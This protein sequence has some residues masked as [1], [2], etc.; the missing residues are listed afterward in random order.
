MHIAKVY[1]IMIGAPSDINEEI[2]IAKN[3]IHRWNVINSEY[4]R[5][6]LLPLHW[7]DN[8]YPLSGEHPQKTIDKTVV[9]KSDLLICIFCSRLGSP[10]DT[11]QSGSLE[12]ID[13][14]IKAGKDV[15]LF[16][17]K[18]VPTPQNA[19]DIEQLQKLISYKNS[20]QSSNLWWEYNDV[21]DFGNLL[22]EK[23]EL[24]VNDKWLSSEN[25]KNAV[26]EEGVVL[27]LSKTEVSIPCGSS[28]YLDIDGVEIDKCSLKLLDRTIG[29]A[30]ER[31]ARIKIEGYK[32]GTTKLIVSYRNLHAECLVTMTP[33][34]MLCGNPILE[35]GKDKDY[36]NEKCA[37]LTHDFENEN[38]IKCRETT[39]RFIIYHY[40]LFEEDKL[41]FVFSQIEVLY[42]K[43]NVLTEASHC[44]GERY[45]RI[46]GDIS[47]E[48]YQYNDDFY[49]TSLN[50]GHN[51]NK[52]YFCYAPTKDIM[53]R[54]LERRNN[55][56]HG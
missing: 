18:N 56:G 41:Q 16:F 52:W 28:A 38:C 19:R 51:S 30:S 53:D 21:G 49:V 3:V 31:N 12:E 8:A 39:N 15:M 35:F 25:E 29:H 45:E 54:M 14:H 23:L 32:V 44:M 36:I 27:S 40:Y 7:S 4:R 26:A 22:R 11:H 17:K 33:M 34:Y 42:S 2:Q 10:T 43:E 6:V 48:W 13:E 24:Y 37:N 5:R 46:S 1:K 20:I 9:V 55:N 47:I 50:P